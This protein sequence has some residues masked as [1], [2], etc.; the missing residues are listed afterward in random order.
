MTP[1]YDCQMTEFSKYIVYVDES[2]DAN[3]SATPEYPLLCLNYCMFE[4]EDYL[5]NL[6]PKFNRLKFDYWGCDNIVLHERDLRKSDKI[7]DPAIRSKYQRL[8]GQ[9]RGQFMSDLSQIMS[10]AKFRCFCVIIDKPK[11]PSRH[12]SFDPYH[13]SLSRGLRQIVNFLKAHA[14][15]ELDKELHVVFEKRGRDDD[16]AL[17]KAYQQVTV[18]GSLLGPL[19]TYDFSNFRLELMDKKSN[20]TGLQIADLTARPIGNHYLHESGQRDSL[21]LRAVSILLEKLY[22]CTTSICETG[23]YDVFHEGL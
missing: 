15:E 12:K 4:K 20:S 23:K 22:Y 17:S 21:D 13:I 8:N 3:W 14:P 10:E 5:T 7:K 2:G 19:E 18:Q 11:V 16:A 1:N 9:K 6:V